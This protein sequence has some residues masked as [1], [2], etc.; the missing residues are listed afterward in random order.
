MDSDEISHGS[1]LTAAID[2]RPEPLDG[3]GR[4]A[5]NV[6][7]PGREMSEL[8][9]HA[10][11][12]LVAVRRFQGSR[13]SVLLHRSEL[14]HAR[15]KL[16]NLQRLFEH[17]EQGTTVVLEQQKSS[18]DRQ[19]LRG[20]H[21]AVP[22]TLADNSKHR[23]EFMNQ[24]NCVGE[25]ENALSALEFAHAK[26]DEELAV[27]VGN[28]MVVLQSYMGHHF[29]NGLQLADEAVSS[30]ASPISDALPPLL[31]QYFDTAGDIT[32]LQ[33]KL[34]ETEYE[35]LREKATREHR[36]DQGKIFEVS[37]EAFKE[38]YM[39]TCRS[40]NEQ[41]II[42][43]ETA[44]R[45]KE[46]CLMDGMDPDEWRKKHSEE[47]EFPANASHH[48]SQK[49]FST[50]HLRPSAMPVFHTQ[51]STQGDSLFHTGQHQPIFQLIDP[52]DPL[53]RVKDW[54]RHVPT[55]PDEDPRRNS[56]YHLLYNRS[57]VSLPV[58]LPNIL[59]FEALPFDI[60]QAATTSYL[61][62]SPQARDLRPRRNYRTVRR[63][64]EPI[65]VD[66]T[67]VAI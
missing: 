41:L 9:E 43:I 21:H 64:S 45:L 28:L 22:A 23:K 11:Q 19:S 55:E 46:Q 18:R 56:K 31:S 44:Q 15:G 67:T 36:E 37:D 66:R 29:G 24:M 53:E 10:Q 49:S 60:G 47:S 7:S 6:V 14:Q 5:S 58:L 26:R 40:I 4:S 33:E 39:E 32:L 48:R 3:H 51:N 38:E 35:H 20:S 16:A 17:S 54:V 59:A 25:M 27:G 50:R 57:T 12:C 42:A 65:P 8:I 1:R 13:K 63:S 34:M 2:A 61:P 62:V 52:E 30:V